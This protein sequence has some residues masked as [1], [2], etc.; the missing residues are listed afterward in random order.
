MYLI[1]NV[2]GEPVKLKIVEFE[3]SMFTCKLFLDVFLGSLLEGWS[4]HDSN[5]LPPISMTILIRIY[6]IV[7]ELSTTI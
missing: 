6:K 4:V 3:F 1:K 7:F 2:V 5:I